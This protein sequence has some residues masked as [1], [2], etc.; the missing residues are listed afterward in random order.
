MCKEFLTEVIEN[1]GSEREIDER[2]RPERPGR[3]FRE[4]YGA[5]YRRER[6]RSPS[7]LLGT[8]QSDIDAI[9]YHTGLELQILSG[10]SGQTDARLTGKQFEQIV[11]AR[12]TDQGHEGA[13]LERLV[14]E[15]IEQPRPDN[16]AYDAVE[17]H[18]RGTPA[19]DVLTLLRSHGFRWIHTAGCWSCYGRNA[20]TEWKLD[21]IANALGSPIEPAPSDQGA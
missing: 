2:L 14:A 10:S 17:L 1:G 13:E 6:E 15:I 5:I 18:F 4:C 16:P 9:H 7:E 12:L 11:R 3:L 19:S 20:A 8:Y 21:L